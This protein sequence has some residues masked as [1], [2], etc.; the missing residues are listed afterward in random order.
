MQWSPIVLHIKKVPS[1]IFGLNEAFLCW[2]YI[3]SLLLCNYPRVLWFPRPLKT[4]TICWRCSF[5]WGQ[6]SHE[7]RHSAI[8]VG[9]SWSNKINTQNKTI[10]KIVRHWTEFIVLVPSCG[11][12]C[13]KRQG[14]DHLCMTN[15]IIFTRTYTTYLRKII[16][17]V[18]LYQMFHASLQLSSYVTQP[19]PKAQ[20]KKKK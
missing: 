20:L 8:L 12:L 1:L 17:L 9:L 3:F 7:K 13:N 5:F 11:N 15:T 4:C 19:F 18:F 6:D 10:F 14:W 16:F 2:V